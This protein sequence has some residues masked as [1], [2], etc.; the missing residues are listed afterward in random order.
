LIDPARADRLGACRLL[1]QDRRRG[2]ARRRS[3]AR[4]G[5]ARRNLL[6]MKY[7]PT[8]KK[9]TKLASAQNVNSNNRHWVVALRSGT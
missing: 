7:L 4:P 1:L 2:R 3:R 8:A 9:R 5:S 6:R